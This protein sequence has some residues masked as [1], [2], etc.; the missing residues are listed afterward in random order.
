MRWTTELR[1]WSTCN[2]RSGTDSCSIARTK[3]H[4]SRA[5]HGHQPAVTMATSAIPYAAAEKD[6]GFEYR[7]SC[8]DES[9]RQLMKTIRNEGA[10]NK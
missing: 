3:E 8:L 1:L 5:H 6:R 9:T 10:V 4:T 2:F 7:G